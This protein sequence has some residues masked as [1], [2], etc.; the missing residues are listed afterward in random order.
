[1]KTKYDESDHVMVRATRAFT[2]K[3]T[4]VFGKCRKNECGSIVQEEKVYMF[5]I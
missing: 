5:N 4:D 2:E 3:L 1:M